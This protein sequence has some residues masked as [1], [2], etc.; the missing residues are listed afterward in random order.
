M[1]TVKMTMR[2]IYLSVGVCVL[3]GGATKRGHSAESE[4]HEQRK[5]LCSLVGSVSFYKI[6]AASYS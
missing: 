5:S 1:L 3:M 4:K 2:M 6:C